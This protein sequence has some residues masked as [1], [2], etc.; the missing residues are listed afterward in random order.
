MLL[1]LGSSTA[2]EITGI[3][4]ESG[5]DPAVVSANGFKVLEVLRRIEPTATIISAPSPTDFVLLGARV[6]DAAPSVTSSVKPAVPQI[7]QA[8]TLVKKAKLKKDRKFYRYSASNPDRRVD[9]KTG[10][11]KAGSYAVPESEV[12]FIPTGFAAVGRLALPFLQPASH[13]YEIRAASGTDVEFGTVAPA[14]GQAGGGVEAYFVRG[15]T[16]TEQPPKSAT[17]IDDE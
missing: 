12:P 7:A 15:A 16:N 3:E 17:T 1:V 14:F 11:L 10:N 6:G 9:P 4:F 8:S 2:I 13:K 5:V